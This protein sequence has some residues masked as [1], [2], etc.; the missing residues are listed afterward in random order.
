MTKVV[1]LLLVIETKI[2]FQF[3]KGGCKIDFKKMQNFMTSYE[4]TRVKALI[5]ECLL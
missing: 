3:Q 1:T 2:V 5:V 4:C